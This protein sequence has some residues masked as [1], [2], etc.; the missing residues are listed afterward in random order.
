MAGLPAAQLD[1]APVPRGLPPADWLHLLP[2]G[3]ITAHDWRPFVRSDPAAGGGLF[4]ADGVDLRV[5]HEDQAA[6]PETC[7]KGRVPAAGWIMAL[8]A[9]SDRVWGQV[10]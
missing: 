7:T 1:L 10:V 4:V 3:K 2:L 6:M 8:T 9:G 5:D